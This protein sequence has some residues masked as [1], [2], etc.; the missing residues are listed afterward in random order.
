MPPLFSSRLL[1]L[2]LALM[3]G[4]PATA[5]PGTP[6]DGRVLRT[7]PMGKGYARTGVNAVI[8]RGS[9]LVTSESTQYAAFYDEQGRFVLARR[10]LG[11]PH[12]DTQ[13][14]RYTGNVL[15]VHN[16]ISLGAD[17]KGVLHTAWDHHNHPLNYCQ[18]VKPGSLEL[19]DKLPMTGQE[20][21]VC[22]PQ[23]FRL[24]DGDLLF[25]YRTGMSGAGDLS[26][27]R[28]DVKTGQWSALP[29]PIVAG[30]GQRNAY[31][32]TAIDP[33]SGAI[34]LSWCWR[35]R[36]GN[37]DLLTNHDICYARS[38]DG[39][40]TWLRANGQA[41]SLPIT[42]DSAE[43][44]WP[45]PQ[46][47][48]LANMTSMAIDSLGHPFIVNSW[49]PAGEQTEQ[50]H[51]VFHDGTA[52]QLRRVGQREGY[53]LRLGSENGFTLSRP[54]VL[55]D[56]DDRAL[57]VIRDAARGSRISVAV[58][59]DTQYRTWQFEDLT[60]ESVGDWEPTH[61][62]TRW[63]RDGVLSLFAQKC[64]V[65]YPRPAPPE[66]GGEPAWV[67]EW[68]PTARQLDNNLKCVDLSDLD[69]DLPLDVVGSEEILRRT[70]PWE[71]D[72]LGYPTVVRNDHGR[73]PDRRYY[74][75]YAH[76][77]MGSGIA[78]AVAESIEGPYVKLAQRD[79]ERSDSRVLKCPGRPG[80][81]HFSSPCVVWNGAEQRWFM[82]FH[83]DA[84]EWATGGGHQRIALAT[85]E[86]LAANVWKPWTG[87]DGKLVPVFP[88]TKERWMNSQSSYHAVQR[89][90]DGRWL[91][92]LRGTGGEYSPEG[93]WLQDVCKLGFATSQDGRRWDYFADNPVIHQGLGG[94]RKGV[95][96]PHFVG[97]QG[98]GEYLL[99]WS[100]SQPYDGG[101]EVI[102][103]RT[104]DFRTVV[105]DPRGYAHWQM[106]DGLVN[107][108]REGDRL[109]L[110]AGR[111]VHVMNLPVRKRA[112]DPQPRPEGGL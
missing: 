60:A 18:S 87:D 14:T 67:L 11:S 94:G 93:K 37:A 83:H 47:S 21:A 102:Y 4:V 63:E 5:E 80:P 105:R 111:F 54:L 108:W 40:K 97:Y 29:G 92:F 95:Y 34:H 1:T 104:R 32:Q 13:V 26:I 84:N 42:A 6:E 58:S 107:P 44:A 106:G 82:Y 24:P 75:Y 15:D 48:N 23:F 45:V 65:G 90:P 9:S 61:D 33:H 96:R 81:A 62:A 89:L 86:D 88:V 68:K 100:E 49:K 69:G 112:D 110:F 52:W 85:C 28:Y 66:V 30:D 7:E 19:T 57:V 78:C 25:L 56:Q 73:H 31:W 74:L 43:V 2:L 77:D 55:I 17:G 51:L 10:T 27:N 91:G 3:L 76:H 39:G 99:C 8:F 22:Y 101:P 50:L 20:K 71:N 46:Q 36:K 12:W 98:K 38:N 64:W 109:Y 72:S 41:Y 59:L 53:P 79:P 103:G 16:V 70:E 35:E